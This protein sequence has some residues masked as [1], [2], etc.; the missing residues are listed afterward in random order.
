MSQ[1]QLPG[2]GAGVL[3]VV[4]LLLVV[5][6][7]ADAPSAPVRAPQATPLTELP[8]PGTTPTEGAAVARALSRASRKFVRQPDGSIL[9]IESLSGAD[10]RAYEVR[11]LIGTNGL[12][13]T[14]EVSRDGQLFAR[15]VNDWTE[16]AAGFN[17]ERQRM[18]RFADDGT[19]QEFDSQ[20]HGGI[21]R[22]AGAP[23]FV[24]T[25]SA[26][27]AW[28]AASGPPRARLRSFY[29][30]DDSSGDQWP[31]TGPCDTQARAVEAALD[32]WLVSLAALGG[33]YLTGNPLAA[34]TAWTYEVKAWRDFTRAEETL[35][36]CVAEAGK[37]KE[38]E[39]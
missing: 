13:R 20:I 16:T 31:I 3:V 15:L 1:V 7:C 6:A 18:V 29:G 22:L 8:R 23:V 12:S 14:V 10:H 27:A 34:F 37:K 25:R 2:R 4:T 17:L 5:S 21:R 36:A 30:M 9:K 32:S 33:A 19:S 26:A 39:F 35:N 28:S 24:S 11:S 38:D